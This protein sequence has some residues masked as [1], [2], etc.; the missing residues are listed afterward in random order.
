L[1]Q[2]GCAAAPPDRDSPCHGRQLGVSVWA[3][4]RRAPYLRWPWARTGPVRATVT[5]DGGC[6][7]GMLSDDAD[8]N[9][10]T[11]AMRAASF[12]PLAQTLEEL[13][14]LGPRRITV[15]ALWAGDRPQRGAQRHASRSKRIIR[16]TGLGTKRRYVGGARSGH[17]NTINLTTASRC[18]AA[19]G[20]RER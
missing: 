7:C 12:E 19:A 9:A 17:N 15:A 10:E 16:T 3:S 11:W 14:R 13:L 4:G 2:S 5:E 8:W 6:A 1:R 18:S 20:Y